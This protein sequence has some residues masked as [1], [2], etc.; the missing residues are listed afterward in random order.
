MN[1]VPGRESRDGKADG[2]GSKGDSALA[3]CWCGVSLVGGSIP[4][5]QPDGGI[6]L[7]GGTVVT[8][9]FGDGGLQWDKW[10][11]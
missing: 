7:Q 1:E 10:K 2:A 5:F 3:A 11:S 4:D 6:D 9:G 8:L